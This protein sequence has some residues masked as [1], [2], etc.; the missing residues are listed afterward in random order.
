[1][2]LFPPYSPLFREAEAHRAAQAT[3]G[4]GHDNHAPLEIDV[5]QVLYEAA[6][7]LKPADV[8]S[9]ADIRHTW[10]YTCTISRPHGHESNE[11]FTTK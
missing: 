8:S 11:K 9:A 7:V 1:M 5:G 10:G 6:K 4:T 3:V 2:I